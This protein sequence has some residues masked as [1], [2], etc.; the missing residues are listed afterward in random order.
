[1]AC[2]GHMSTL[3]VD[4][5]FGEVYGA[6]QRDRVRREKQEDDC[7]GSLSVVSEFSGLKTPY[8]CRR[9]ALIF[10]H[11]WGLL[12]MSAIRQYDPL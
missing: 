4:L 10:M 11:R 7:G 1:M 5:T 8:V 3:I 6:P 12:E 2:M 9:H